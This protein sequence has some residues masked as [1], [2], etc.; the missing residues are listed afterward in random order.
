MSLICSREVSACIFQPPSDP[1]LVLIHYH[2]IPL[3]HV[4]DVGNIMALLQPVTS[5][6]LQLIIQEVDLETPFWYLRACMPQWKVLRI[7]RWVLI[8]G[9]RSSYFMDVRLQ[10]IV[11]ISWIVLVVP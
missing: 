6:R 1:L 8:I 11:H 10:L 7:W 2:H 4:N 5:C 3:S 9:L